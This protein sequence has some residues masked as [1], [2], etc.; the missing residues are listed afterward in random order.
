MS[1]FFAIKANV[2]VYEPLRC[3]SA[4][5]SRYTKVIKRADLRKPT[6]SNGLYTLLALVAFYNIFK[7]FF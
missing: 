7:N 2:R 6:T 5:L 1:V 4:Y 3:Q